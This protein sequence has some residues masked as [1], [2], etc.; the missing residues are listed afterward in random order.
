MSEKIDNSGQ[1]LVR[2]GLATSGSALR[3]RLLE[4]SSVP[5]KVTRL[6]GNSLAYVRL[7]S[8]STMAFSPDDFAGYSGIRLKDLG[9]VEGAD[10][11]LKLEGPEPS[12]WVSLSTDPNAL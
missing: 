2:A 4:A 10:V 5:G 6:V 1:L 12:S 3:V 9:L 11:E 7:A 8:G